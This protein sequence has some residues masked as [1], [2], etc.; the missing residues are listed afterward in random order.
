V[1]TSW[2]IGD[3]HNFFRT[4]A[5][6]AERGIDPKV[7]DDQTGRLTFTGDIAEGI[8]HLLENRPPYGTYN[9]TGSG[10]PATWADIARSVFELGG[11]DPARITGV[12]TAEYFAV[13]TNPVAPRPHNSVLDLAKINDAGYAPAEYL[14]S[15]R[16]YLAA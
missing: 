15:L 3:G 13:A 16:D 11:H 1:R 4:M 2:V 5:S 6:L 9:L 14:L 12:S 7:V 10:T 8:R